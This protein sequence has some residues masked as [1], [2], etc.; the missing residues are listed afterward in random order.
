MNRKT[1]L[2]TV[3][4]LIV[5]PGVLAKATY[6][7][8]TQDDEPIYPYYTQQYFI[9]GYYTGLAHVWVFEELKNKPGYWAV[10]VVD[11]LTH[12]WRDDFAGPF[13]RPTVMRMHNWW[14]YAGN[15]RHEAWL[16]DF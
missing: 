2:K 14:R 11:S 7:S 15:D 6:P 1:F 16:R 8:F 9:G 12:R 13:D 5:L 4:G 10:K 3:I